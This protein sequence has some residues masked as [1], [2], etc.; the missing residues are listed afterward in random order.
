MKLLAATYK[1]A[2]SIFS[3]HGGH[4]ICYF[5]NCARLLGH[6]VEILKLHF[7]ATLLALYSCC[8]INTRQYGIVLQCC[9]IY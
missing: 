4:W 5:L 9:D 3:P 8:F 1:Y 6:P 2:A 7:F